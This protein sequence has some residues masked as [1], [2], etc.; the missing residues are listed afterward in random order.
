MNEAGYPEEITKVASSIEQKWDIMEYPL[1]EEDLHPSVGKK[2][3]PSEIWQK[4]SFELNLSRRPK[5]KWMGCSP[6]DV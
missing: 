1:E 3:V 6:N 4:L 2:E 5:N